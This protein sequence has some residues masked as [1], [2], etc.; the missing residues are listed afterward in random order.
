MIG[1]KFLQIDQGHAGAGVIVPGDVIKGSDA[2]PIDRAMAKAVE[3]VQEFVNEL[4]G[5]GSMGRN[6]NEVLTNLKNVTAGLDKIVSVSQP[7]AENVVERMDGITMKLDGIL[8]QVDAILAKI[9][10]GEGVAGALVSD[11]KMKE[12]V[13]ST[14]DNLKDASAS[15]KEIVGRVGGFRTYWN[16]QTRYEPL[17]HASKGDLGVKIYPREGRY[18]YLGASN[19]MN[20]RDRSRGVNY[21]TGN[22]IDALMGWDV[23]AFELYG[24]ALHGTGGAGVKYRPFYTSPKW[25]RVRFLL[26]ASDFSRRRTIKDRY[27]DKPRYDAG[28]EFMLN[29][30]VSAGMRVNDMREVKR[31]NYTARVLFEDK[32]IAYLLGL[33]SLGSAGARTSA[34]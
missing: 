31:V 3:D 19:L 34:K 33:A 5:D 10:A 26:E 28:L 30:Y 13:S 24:G 16:V 2:L 25:D 32:D 23:R 18:Y 9:T 8:I 1:S 22:T 15:V 17:A 27:F 21:E 6:L 12:D 14:L 29:K 20:S 7:H 11:K 4:R